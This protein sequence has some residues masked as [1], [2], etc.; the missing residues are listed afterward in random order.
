MYPPSRDWKWSVA[1]FDE[2][3]LNAWCMPG[4]KMAIYTGIIHKLKLSDDEIG[5]IMGHEIAHALLGHGRERMS[6][7]IAM[8]GGMQL[9]SILAGRDLSILTPVADIALTLPNSRENESEAD[10]YGIELA[11]RAGYDPRT[12]VR[13]WEKMSAAS[14]DGPPQFLSTHPAPGNRIQAL[15]ALMPQMMP[16]YEKAR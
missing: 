1:V 6:R 16:I 7:A 13:L 14:G 2:P 10:R 15:N 5:Q 8:Q 9:G 11:A 4:G 3:T 12:A